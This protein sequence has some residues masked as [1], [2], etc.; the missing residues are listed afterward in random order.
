VGGGLD[1]ETR[2]RIRRARSDDR[3][4]RAY[5]ATRLDQELERE[6]TITSALICADCGHAF[7]QHAFGGDCT[8][9]S[10]DCGGF[11]VADGT[12][13]GNGHQAA[14]A[15]PQ[16]QAT[17]AV[18]WTRDEIVDRIKQWADDHG[19]PPTRA[20][21]EGPTTNDRPNMQLV[22]KR[23][24]KWGDAIV[25]AGFPRP[26]KGTRKGASGGGITAEPQRRQ[27]AHIQPPATRE[28]EAPPS[29]SAIPEPAPAAPPPA[30]VVD[31]APTIQITTLG[32]ALGRW[33][34][35]RHGDDCSLD[36]G[37]GQSVEGIDWEQLAQL[38][39]LI[40]A[41]GQA[42]GATSE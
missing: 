18:V 32:V 22:A 13:N 10:C 37:N 26:T 12:E 1:H 31:A 39:A 19:E 9:T 3:R 25:A 14:D 34:L 42:F 33:Q 15:E 7:R 8:L 21:W 36:F 38:P 6:M 30:V 17:K 23:F 5:R 4:S 20:Q 2:Q 24:G 11:V 41:V 40:A 35:Y 27:P 28:A 29:L 16:Q